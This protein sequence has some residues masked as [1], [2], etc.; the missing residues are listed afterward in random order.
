MP[1]PPLAHTRTQ[2]G[3]TTHHAVL[4]TH[5]P[6]SPCHTGSKKGKTCSTR[7]SRVVPPPHRSTTRA[8]T[9]GTRPPRVVPPAFPRSPVIWPH[10]RR[11]GQKSIIETSLLFFSFSFFSFSFLFVRVLCATAFLCEKLVSCLLK[12]KKKKHYWVRVNP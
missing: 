7:P 10:V 11:Q 9:C 1:M 2:K 3:N 6:T 8:K 5:P 12:K 4:T